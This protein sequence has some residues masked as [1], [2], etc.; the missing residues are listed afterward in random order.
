MGTEASELKMPQPGTAKLTAK[1]AAYLP[2][3]RPSTQNRRIPVWHIEKARIGNSRNVRLDL[4]VN[5]VQTQTKQ[6]PADGSIQDVAFDVKI[7][8][9]SWV[10]LRIFPSSHSNPIF[11]VVGDKPIRAS[12][13]SAQWCLSGVD[14][15]WSQKKRFY[16]GE[17][18]QQAQAAYDHA[19]EVYKRIVSESEVD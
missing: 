17:E 7:D 13:K 3:Q 15:C 5:G 10:A 16:K 12:K 6:I 19:K 18:L 4:I 9:S 11:V 2:E 14:Q 1:V 8:R